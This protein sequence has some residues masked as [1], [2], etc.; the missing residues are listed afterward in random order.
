M[1]RKLIALAALA[2]ITTPAM[3]ELPAGVTTAITGAGTDAGT[4]LAAIIVVAVG[5]WALKR[6]KALFGS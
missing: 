6:V 5:I 4:A 2:V 1:K 3:A